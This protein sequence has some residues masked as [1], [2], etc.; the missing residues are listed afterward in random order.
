MKILMFVLALSFSLISTLNSQS[1]VAQRASVYLEECISFGEMVGVSGAIW[2]DGKT[3]WQDGKGFRDRE[4]QV[5]AEANM[6][7]R[8]AS[9][10]KT[11]TAVAILQLW[12][13]GKLKLDDPVIK[14]LPSFPSKYSAITINH[15]LNHTSG[16]KAYRSRSEAF[17]TVQY[18]SLKDA[19]AV[20]QDRS[21]ANEPGEAYQYTTYGY[22]VLGAIIEA[23]SGKDYRT[24]MKENIWDVAGMEN[25][26][27]E[28]FGQSYPNKSMLYKKSDSGLYQD[29]PTNLSVKVPGG[30]IQSTVGDLLKFGQAVIQHKLIKEATFD[31]MVTDKGIKPGGNPYAMGWFLY[32]K[33][34]DPNGRIIGHSGSQSGTSTQFM[35]YLDH[36]MVVATL[37]NTNDAWNNVYSLNSKLAQILIDP[38]V[39]ASPIR[40][41]IP[42]DISVLD[43]HVGTYDAEDGKPIE[44]YRKE[45]SLYSLKKGFNAFKLYAQSETVFFSRSIP[46]T[47]EFK[48]TDGKQ[49]KKMTITEGEDVSEH[50]LISD[51]KSIARGLYHI[52]ADQD[53]DAGIKWFNAK[54]DNPAYYL[55]KETMN[56]VGYE[57]ITAGEIKEALDVF[58]LNHQSFPKEK[59]LIDEERMISFGD[60]LLAYEYDEMAFAY[61][62]FNVV[63]NPTSWK[64]YYSLGKAY[65]KVGK[66]SKA[67][68]T[69]SMALK[70]NPENEEIKNVLMKL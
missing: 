10:S 63:A 40:K 57:L 30:G 56:A 1:D 29:I 31:V 3:I 61:Y 48:T 55:D 18:N 44:I 69:L 41:A 20:F 68:K 45:K 59:A 25:T 26:D 36:N 47:V 42:M 66:H 28:I 49:I 13:K 2:K 46:F 39:L 17:S 54:L 19:I 4:N 34:G 67:K 8:T 62:E 15:L 43:R 21:L 23:A 14:H 22:V 16:I 35:I 58:K 7:H 12:E 70:L 5:A 37:A 33:E 9:I 52:M 24:Y 6:L 11:M 38:K 64:G 53:A 32:G 60:Q 65:Q 27:V 51:K 50:V